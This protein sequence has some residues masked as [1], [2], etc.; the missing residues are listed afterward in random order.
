MDTNRF[1]KL[2]GE[3]EP[4][5]LCQIVIGN[6]ALVHGVIRFALGVR[7]RVDDSVVRV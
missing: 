1:A 7:M 4:G 3:Q 5:N 2:F 6:I